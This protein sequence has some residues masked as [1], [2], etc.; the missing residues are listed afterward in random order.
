MTKEVKRIP[1]DDFEREFKRFF[2]YVVDEHASVVV[3]DKEG[4]SVVIQP[5]DTTSAKRT[6]TD[7][8]WAAFRAAAGS[9]ADVDTD[10]FLEDIYAS[11]KS[12][13]PPVDL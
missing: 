4:H 3:E 7:E 11:R 5:L 12:S 13:R 1:I 2:A 6:I 8:D 9:W 10:K